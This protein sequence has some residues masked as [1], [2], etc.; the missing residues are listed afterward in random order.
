MNLQ[1]LPFQ[2]WLRRT[3]VA[4]LQADRPVPPRSEAEVEA[5]M[6]ANYRWN[7]TANLFDGAAFWFGMSFI[8]SSTIVPLFVSKLTPSPLAIGLVA[9]IA[10]GG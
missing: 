1:N 2:R 8:S 3:A 9:V 4:L 6:V 7:F 5:E 10:S